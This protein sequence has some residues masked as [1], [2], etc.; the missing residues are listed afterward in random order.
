M[1]GTNAAAAK[2]ALIN[3]IKASPPPNTLVDYAYVGKSDSASRQY[4]WGGKS[5]FQQDY[6]ALRGGTKP[7][8]EVLTIDLHLSVYQPGGAFEDTD[9]ACVA[10]GLVVETLIA[11][12]VQ[13]GGTIPGLR[14]AGIEGGELDNSADDDGVESH[15][16]YHVIFKSR[17]F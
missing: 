12:D 11:N 2:L 4:L 15:I 8:D 9:A 16:T 7:R 5:T 6:S 1:A 3:L 10:I 17:L 13:L 14:Y